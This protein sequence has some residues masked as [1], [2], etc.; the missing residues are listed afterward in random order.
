MQALT[1]L[2]QD[3]ATHLSSALGEDIS[4]SGQQSVGG[5]CINQAF[6]VNGDNG[7]SYFVK[8]SSADGLEMFAAEAEGL[9]EIARS[10]TIKAPQ[11]F[12]WGVS[13][14]HAYI[15]MERLE[16]GGGSGDAIVTLGEQLAAM[17]RVT[18]SNFG[19]FRNNTIGATLQINAV[20]HDWIEFY[21]ERRLRFQLDLAARKGYRGSLQKNGEKLLDKLAHFFMNRIFPRKWAISIMDKNTK[22][23]S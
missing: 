12:C 14:K 17:H 1:Q 5:G 9:N 2:W 20:H 8:L 22:D 15:V 18:Q 11:A 6:V 16:F 7:Q 23:L 3:I 13:G 21:R 10:N 4:F 19:W